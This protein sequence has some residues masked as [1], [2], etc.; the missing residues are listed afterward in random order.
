MPKLS[1]PPT[2]NRIRVKQ[3]D[4]QVSFSLPDDVTINLLV[5]VSISGLSVLFIGQGLSSLQTE[6]IWTGAV[7]IPWF[8]ALIF[9]AVAGLFL[10]SRPVYYVD[11]P[12]AGGEVCWQWA[13][14]EIVIEPQALRLQLFTPF[15]RR[16]VHIPLSHVLRIELFDERYVVLLRHKHDR[17]CIIRTRYQDYMIGSRLLPVEQDWLVTELSALLKHM[18]DSDL[19]K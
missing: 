3:T 19:E 9:L 14:V 8:V 1:Q 13:V 18:Q 10:V 15:R 7:L 4:Q 12:A 11:P 2:G 16:W 17:L 6:S 5:A